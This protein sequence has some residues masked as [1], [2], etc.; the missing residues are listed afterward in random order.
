MT[1]AERVAELI[2]ESICEI[3]R[4]QLSDPRIG[5]VSITGVEVCPDLQNAKIYVSIFGDEPKKQAAMAAFASASGFIRSQLALMLNMRTTPG[6]EF[7]RD[8]GLERGSK[9]LGILS[10]LS[11]SH[12]QKPVRKNKARSKKR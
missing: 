7:V 12:D 2:K 5:F 4:E 8:D 9:V 1:R 6:L 3:I 11:D 10:Q